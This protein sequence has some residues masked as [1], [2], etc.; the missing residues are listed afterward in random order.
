[1]RTGSSRTLLQALRADPYHASELVLLRVLAQ[2]GPNVAAPNTAGVPVE[3]AT[4]RL[5]RRATSLA[6]RDGAITG[7]S[8]YVGMP[9]ASRPGQPPA[10]GLPDSSA[11]RRSPT[12]RRTPNRRSRIRRLTCRRV[13]GRG[14][15]SCSRAP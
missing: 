8:F 12:M 15:A 4:K 13:P 7:S 2:V 3:Q 9:S 5:I 14:R 6:R 11:A 1:M 10:A